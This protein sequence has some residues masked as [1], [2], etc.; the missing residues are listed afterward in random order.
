MN[1]QQL[2]DA[3]GGLDGQIANAVA[4]DDTGKAKVTLAGSNGTTLANVTAG[5]L[6]ATSMEAVNGG[7][8]FKLAD[9]IAQVLGG[10]ASMGA[11]GFLGPVYTLQSGSYYSVGDALGALDG[12]IGS[13]SGRLDGMQTSLTGGS[14]KLPEG[15]GNGMAI[16]NSSVAKDGGDIAIGHGSAVDADNS[17]VIGTGASSTAA[18]TDSVTV[19]AYA[20]NDAASGVALGSGASVQAGADNAVALGA[21]SVADRA[22]TVSVG[23]GGSE[24]QITN[25]AAGTQGT[26]A[27]NVSQVQQA[28]VD[29]KAYADAGDQATLS[30]AKSYTDTKLANTVS[31]ADYNS[32]KSDVNTRFSVLDTRVSRV[33]A[34]GSAMSGMAGA[35]AAAPGTDNRVSA[36]VGGYGGQGALAVGYAKRIPGN[37]AVLVGASI[38]GGGESSGTIGVSFGW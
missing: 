36:A 34:M 8:L 2:Q 21:G 32:F 25:V 10:G 26:D 11:A 18:A 29:A 22:N 3:V 5:M 6:S 9:D 1:V 27:A 38:A 14:W 20:S 35:I 19:G 7:Q 30:S 23:A 33:G 13:L 37:G 28:V 15:I 31:T 17:V 4:Y 24:R 12:A 16:G